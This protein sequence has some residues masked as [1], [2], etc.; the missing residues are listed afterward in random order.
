MQLKGCYNPRTNLMVCF[1]V[2]FAALRSKL[3]Y[4]VLLFKLGSAVTDD[5]SV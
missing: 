5:V 3:F 1:K 2:S 4:F